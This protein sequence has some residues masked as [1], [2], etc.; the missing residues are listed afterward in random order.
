MEV[1]ISIISLPFFALLSIIGHIFTV[2]GQFA[3]LAVVFF[4]LWLTI[5]N[6]YAQVFVS[7]VGIL[8]FGL[9]YFFLGFGILIHFGVFDRDDAKCVREFIYDNIWFPLESTLPEPLLLFLGLW[10][11]FSPIILASFPPTDRN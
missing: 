11:I 3:I 5:Y 8:M 7:L 10:A 2:L 6:K 1:L 9:L 4:V